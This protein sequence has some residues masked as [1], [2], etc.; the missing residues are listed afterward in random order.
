MADYRF[1]RRPAWIAGH[2]LAVAA[3]ATFVSAGLWQLDR[4]DQ[5]RAQNALV[6]SR[7]SAEPVDVG[8]VLDPAST[9][10]EADAVRFAAVV[11]TG[12][13]EGDPVLVRTNQDGTS[14]ARV[15][16]PLA[17]DGGEVVLVLRGF[18]V[19][20]PD[21]SVV[22]PEPPVGEVTVEGL[23]FPIRRLDQVNRR[24]L[25]GAADGA[26]PVVVQAAAPDAPGLVPVPPPEPGEGPHLSY[27]VQWFL[28]TAVVVVGYPLLLRRRAQQ[29]GS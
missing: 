9:D 11:A 12:T 8:E 23:A 2:L 3:V 7:S 14:G 28:F 1:A 24:A 22:A 21:G 26:L 10:E 4:L 25:E 16:A 13:Y 17:L 29:A 5:R 15:F 27:A 19:Q 6:E 20:G 18:V